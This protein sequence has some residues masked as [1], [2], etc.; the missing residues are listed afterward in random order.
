MDEIYKRTPE[1]LPKCPKNGK[2]SFP[3]KRLPPEYRVAGIK[4]NVKH[5]SAYKCPFCP[6]FHQTHKP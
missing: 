4:G 6:Y 1:T 2:L 5:L 3:S